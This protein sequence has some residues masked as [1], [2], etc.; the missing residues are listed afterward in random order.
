MFEW[1]PDAYPSEAVQ[2]ALV[3]Q[4]QIG[5]NQVCQGFLA[6]EWQHMYTQAAARSTQQTNWTSTV[7]SAIFSFFSQLWR[8]R[9]GALYGTDQADS[10]FIKRYRLMRKV[11]EIFS[12]KG[13][14]LAA[15]RS[16]IFKQSRDYFQKCS[17]FELQN[18]VKFA[19]TIIPFAI[20]RSTEIPSGQTT[21]T[22]YF[23]RRTTS[24]TRDA[25]G[26]SSG[27][28]EKCL[29]LSVAFAFTGG[30]Q[31]YRDAS[32]RGFIWGCLDSVN[33]LALN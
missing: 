29:I 27:S 25:P 1:D 3:V 20:S 5:W 6:R 14:L 23:T 26:T 33:N 24:T 7:Y 30:G 17:M 21:I 19:E 28:Y 11:D 32:P 13:H 31:R 12:V 15:D 18:Y 16:E 2:Q 4:T 10:E 9:N 8:E 22:Q